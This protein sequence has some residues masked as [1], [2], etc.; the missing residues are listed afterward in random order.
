M[1]DPINYYSFKSIRVERI[2]MDIQL[3]RPVK[4]GEYM[5][6]GYDGIYEK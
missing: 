3:N 6:P 2:E 1:N 4:W 5:G